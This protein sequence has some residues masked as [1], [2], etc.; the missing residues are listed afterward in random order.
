MLEDISSSNVSFFI[1]KIYTI[2]D[3]HHRKYMIVQLMFTQTTEMERVIDELCSTYIITELR[4][5][6]LI[7]ST[8]TATT[9]KERKQIETHMGCCGVWLL[10]PCIAF[11]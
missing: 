7:T 11:T 6:R 10:E 1:E 2:K 3:E 8:I 4:F 5:L 9:S